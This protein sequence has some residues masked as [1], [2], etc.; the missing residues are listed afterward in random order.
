MLSYYEYKEI[1]HRLLFSMC[2]SSLAY[3]IYRDNDA[4]GEFISEIAMADWKFN[5]N[6]C[7]DKKNLYP[8]RV[9][10]CRWFIIKYLK[11][12]NE[13]IKCTSIIAD[14]IDKNTSNRQEISD[15]KDFIIHNKILT[16]KENQILKYR[17]E[18]KTLEEIGEKFDVTK[19]A[20]SFA[21]KKIEK[22]YKTC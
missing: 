3:K 1:A 7:A 16:N 19:Q 8:F 21:L 10:R 14:V 18:G 20:I 2:H 13:K 12:Y 9:T 17:I 11:E 22:K 5:S 4:F 6:K 15:I